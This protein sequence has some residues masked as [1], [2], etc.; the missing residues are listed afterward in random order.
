MSKILVGTSLF[1]G[2]NMLPFIEIGL[3]YYILEVGFTA[4]FSCFKWGN[5]SMILNFEIISITNWWFFMSKCWENIIEIIIFEKKIMGCIKNISKNEF[6]WFQYHIFDENTWYDYIVS[7][8]RCC[9]KGTKHV[10]I[11]LW[12][13]EPLVT[14][15]CST[16]NSSIHIHIR[17]V[18]IL[19]LPAMYR[20]HVPW[21]TAKGIPVCSAKNSALSPKSLRASGPEI[22]N[23]YIS[24]VRLHKKTFAPLHCEKGR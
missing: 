20:S 18:Y 6:N 14:V 12:E 17:Y 9:V 2:H 7:R 19:D 4:G 23:Q 3:T 16:Y 24:T 8:T 22:L 21:T 13:I 1:V 10:F 5:S 11:E 15:L